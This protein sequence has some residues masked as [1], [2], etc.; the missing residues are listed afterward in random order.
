[1]IQE[2][3]IANLYIAH[4][5]T[6]IK[7]QQAAARKYPL[8]WMCEMAN[9]VLDGDTGELMEYLHLIKIPKQ[10]NSVGVFLQQ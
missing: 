1:M 5:H 8:K 3:I 4:K 9:D 6:T 7:P 10:K 2:I